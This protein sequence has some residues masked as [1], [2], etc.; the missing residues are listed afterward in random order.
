LPALQPATAKSAGSAKSAPIAQLPPQPNGQGLLFR[1]VDAESQSPLEKVRLTL[2][3]VTEFRARG[4]NTYE[5]DSNGEYVLPIDR[6]PVKNWNSRIEVFKD[7][8]VP[9]FVSWSE[10]QGD[11]ID[12]IPGQYTARL[13]RGTSIGGVVVNE[14][15]EPVPD[16][17]VVFTVSGPSPGASH[18]R[19]R[20]TMMGN[21]HDEVTD[22]Q[23][24]WRCD[25]VPQQFGMITYECLHP[26]PFNQ[27]WI[28][29]ARRLHSPWNE[30]CRRSGFAKWHCQ[31]HAQSGTFCGRH[32]SR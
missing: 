5:T 12:A 10:S 24:Q 3:W 26:L 21:Y 17:R 28:H 22:A 14:E 13:T 30:L 8:Y 27:I 2:T 25:H 15:G 7:G 4:T 11:T 29:N 18:D 9:K 23:G 6:N 16:V 20:L 31:N 1:V 32:G 19:E